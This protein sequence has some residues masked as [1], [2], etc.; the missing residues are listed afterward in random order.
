M[1]IDYALEADTYY[2]YVCVPGNPMVFDIQDVDNYPVAVPLGHKD[3][4]FCD[5]F[6]TRDGS[7]GRGRYAKL[8]TNRGGEHDRVVLYY[9]V[10]RNNRGQAAWRHLNPMLVLASAEK[11]PSV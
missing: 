9:R 6:I 2:E 3:V 8:L 10:S 7:R 5:G 11:L 1:K 4:V